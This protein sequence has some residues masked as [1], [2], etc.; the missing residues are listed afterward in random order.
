VTDPYRPP[1]SPVRDPHRARPR[2]TPLAIL[3]G[4][5][6]DVGGTMVFS[7]VAAT[8]ASILLVSGGVGPED[9]GRALADSATFQ[10]VSLTGGL[11]CTALG[12]Y[13][14]ARFANRSEYATA[15]AVGLASLVFGEATVLFSGQETALWLRLAGDALVIPAALLGGHLRALQKGPVP[16]APPA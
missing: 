3:L 9:L 13:V 15:F 5:V 4:F 10:L 12:G 2:S 1:G 8:V 6:V 16:A 14:A 7:M 11:S